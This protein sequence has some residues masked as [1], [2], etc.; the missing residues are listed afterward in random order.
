M[1]AAW[2]IMAAAFLS[3]G[4]TTTKKTMPPPAKSESWQRSKECSA[5]GEKIVAEWPQRRGAAPE[6]WHNHY[7]P[8]Y[9]RCFVTVCFT[10]ISKDEKNFPSIFTTALVDAFE[11]STVAATCT[12]LRGNSDCAEQI[13]KTMRDLELDEISKASNGKS[14]NEATAAEKE[15]VRKVVGEAKVG[16]NWCTIDGQSVDCAK[17]A[18]FISEHMK[19]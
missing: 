7:S 18:S 2:V 10:Q 8:K 5:Q 9:E 11:R 1:K 14:F 6:D 3:F 13:S 12:L 15:A 17:A 4:Q 16:L 19:N